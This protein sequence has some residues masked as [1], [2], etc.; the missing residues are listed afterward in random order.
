MRAGLVA[1]FYGRAHYGAI[2]GTLAFFLTGARAL[3]P[4]GAGAAYALLGGYDAVFGAMAAL[5]LVASLAMIEVGR[6]RRMPAA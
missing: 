5:S 6:Q 4:V 3:A 1:E 2:N